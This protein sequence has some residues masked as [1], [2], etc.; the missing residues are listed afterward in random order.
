MVINLA[1]VP[2]LGSL[3]STILQ[4]IFYA[5]F[6]F[7]FIF[8]INFIWKNFWL[9]RRQKKYLASQSFFLLRLILPRKNER[10]PE[11]IEG[12]FTA[13]ASTFGKGDWI[14]RNIQG[15]KQLSFSFEIVSFAG[16]IQFFIRT[17]SKYRE[18][19]ESALYVSYPDVEIIEVDDYVK[20]VPE[21]FRQDYN[22]WGTSLVLYNKFPYPIRTYKF[23]EHSIVERKKVKDPLE[24]FLEV[25][26][27]MGKDEEFWFQLVVTPIGADWAK[28]G[29][30]LVKELL[31]KAMAREESKA[32]SLIKEF[33]RQVFTWPKAAGEKKEL[34]VPEG[35]K[36]MIE[37]IQAKLGKVGFKVTP[38]MIYLAKKESFNPA[39]GVTAALS[40]LNDFNLLDM[41]GFKPSKTTK[42]SA[43][44]LFVQKRVAKR[45]K[46]ILDSYK[47][48][49]RG[50]KEEECIL[51]AEELASLYHF[52]FTLEKSEG[53][54]TISSKRGRPPAELP[55]E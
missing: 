34:P 11:T 15:Y 14:K 10:G 16:D 18:L 9:P 42:T 52:P 26:T 44:Y 47:K 23:F 4:I 29:Q 5:I 55:T 8:S 41:N 7:V 50:P 24:S 12:L 48:R 3:P 49:K 36:K 54:K 37:S 30:I 51:N 33:Y 35:T 53:I 6:V 2:I 46:E 13:L 43:D 40:A 38:R 45:Q 22:L 1:N 25:L 39:K 28:E 27:R 31:E 21:F 19:I 32:P 17:P 20:R